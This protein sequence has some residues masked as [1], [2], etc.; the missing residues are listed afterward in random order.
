M[1]PLQAAM[2]ECLTVRLQ[3]ADCRLLTKYQRLLPDGKI[4]KLYG[5]H[6]TGGTVDHL[7]TVTDNP[8]IKLEFLSKSTFA[9]KLL[10]LIS[11][12]DVLDTRIPTPVPIDGGDATSQGSF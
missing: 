9:P 11:T 4:I 3:R 12:I 5:S 6:L 7:V 10:T 8:H 2:G 1:I